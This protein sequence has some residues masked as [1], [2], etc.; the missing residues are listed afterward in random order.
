MLV[1]GQSDQVARNLRWKLTVLVNGF[2]L[3]LAAVRLLEV[4]VLVGGRRKAIRL[5]DGISIRLSLV[6]FGDL[7]G[8]WPI[9]HVFISLN[10]ILV[11]LVEAEF[12]VVTAL[13]LDL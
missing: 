11:V 5:S 2:G 6:C 9:L 3:L 4:L 12:V 13:L 10:L 1:R 8:V 7:S